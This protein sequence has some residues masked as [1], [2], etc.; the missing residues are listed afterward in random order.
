MMTPL[1]YSLIS[2]IIVSLLSLVGII[3]LLFSEEKVNK[4]LLLL[5]S[6]SAGSLMGGAFFHLLP[7]TLEGCSNFLLPSIYILI[8]FCLF[9]IMERI[10]R[11][12]H[13]HKIDCDTHKHL[14]QLN[15]IGDSIHNAIDGLVII[16]TFTISP[17]LGIPVTLSIIFHEIPQE[18]GDFGV[19]LYAGFKK[20][21][22]LLY[23]FLTALTALAG[24]IL[25]YFLLDKVGGINQFLLPFAAGGFIYIAASDLVPEIHQE[26]SIVRSVISFI[27]FFLALLFML[28]LKFI[29]E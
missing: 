26:K 12:H 29:G 3:F 27:I 21:T 28:G 2:V 22:A 11:W 4:T 10:L 18:I 5:V 9:F 13:C 23:N 8:G 19:L 24:V 20:T 7:E 6:F 14:G 17:I 1:L 25:G 16:S 15:L